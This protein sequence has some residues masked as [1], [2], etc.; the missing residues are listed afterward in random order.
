[1]LPRPPFETIARRR[2]H[3]GSFF[4]MHL[5]LELAHYVV[6]LDEAAAGSLHPNDGV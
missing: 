6:R 2:L 3:G 4:E 1:M 5:P